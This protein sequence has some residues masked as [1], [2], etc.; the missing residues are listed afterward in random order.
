MGKFLIFYLD[1]FFPFKDKMNG[2]M[3]FHLLANLFN[4]SS[5]VG[6]F[7]YFNFFLDIKNKLQSSHCGLAETTLTSIHE[8]EG[9]IPGLAQ[10]VKDPVLL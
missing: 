5:I 4:P 1:M 9:L 7:N 2:N 10:W 8:D 6:K 3:V